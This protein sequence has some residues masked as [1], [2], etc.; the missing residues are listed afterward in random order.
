MD[1]GGL[2]GTGARDT[3]VD[4]AR[5][6]H[7]EVVRPL[8]V[9]RWPDLAYAA[10][11]LG[12]GSDVLGLDDAVSRDHD[13][14]LRLTLLLDAH[15]V[16]AVA[17]HLERDLPDR[18]RGLPTRFATSWDPVVRQ[19]VEVASPD[20]FARSRLGL[21]VT[22]DWDVGDWLSL[23]GQAVLEV[24]AGPVFTDT[25][26]GITTVR[27]RLT[28]YPDDIWRHVVAVDWQRLGQVLP[29]LGRAAQRAD[30]LGARVLAA[31][32]VR[33]AVH[34][35]FLLERRWSPYPKWAGTLFAALPRAG[36]ALPLLLA[37]ME[38]PDAGARHG[39]LGAA[40]ELLHEVQRTTGLPT[41]PNALEPF[42]DRPFRTVRASV[43]AL[44]L[45]AVEAP[46]VRGLPDGV[47]SVE[48]W[49]DSTVV[50]TSG[51]RRS[52]VAR[53]LLERG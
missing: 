52:A 16:E 35:G 40:L 31:T 19:R 20:A 47:G 9:T 36:A 22:R 32:A 38:S 23:T 3:G 45:D 29:L 25:H 7:L 8:L 44:L 42:W 2:D 43:P 28:W 6:Y 49:V 18:F 4:L 24:T 13:W 15:R 39:H 34:L 5:A 53:V 10:A 27:D 21:D 50:L 1:G 33:T 17:D 11:R 41:G 48:Q 12:S 14:G 51:S 26:G 37:A 30:E 46:R